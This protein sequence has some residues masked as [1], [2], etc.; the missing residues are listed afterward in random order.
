MICVCVVVD[1]SAR[2]PSAGNTKDR[3]SSARGSGKADVP[4][5]QE[6]SQP[7]AKPRKVTCEEK[8]K[9]SM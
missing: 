9:V 7:V 6:K 8:L 1:S 3:S 2:R 4:S 5:Q